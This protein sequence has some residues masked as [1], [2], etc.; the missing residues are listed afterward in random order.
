MSNIEGF[1]FS[2]NKEN[3]DEKIY[4]NLKQNLFANSQNNEVFRRIF[5]DKIKL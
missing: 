5:A 1:H 2:L 3:V 4:I